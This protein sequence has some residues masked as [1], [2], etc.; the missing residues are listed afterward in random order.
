MS[1]RRVVTVSSIAA[2]RGRPRL[3]AFG[4]ADLALL[5]GCSE[6]AVRQLVKRQ[7][8]DPRDLASICTAWRARRS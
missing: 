1:S 2:R 3:W 5:L 6:G 4:Y 7:R 8:L